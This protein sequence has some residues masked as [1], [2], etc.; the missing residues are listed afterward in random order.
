MGPLIKITNVPIT[1]EMKSTNAQIQ[2]SA[3]S[4]D[5]DISRTEGGGLRIKS[6]PIK[7]SIDTFEARNTI[8]PTTKR[9]IE[10]ASPA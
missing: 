3:Q 9:S 1:V 8:A 10:Q 2:R 5:L 6:N 4:V 7:V